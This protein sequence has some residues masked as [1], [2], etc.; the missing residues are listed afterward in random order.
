MAALSQV[1]FI[2]H[3]TFHLRFLYYQA[4]KTLKNVLKYVSYNKI[5]LI[6]LRLN[7]SSF[8]KAK[9]DIILELANKWM[10]VIIKGL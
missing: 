10:L 6:L 3:A 7:S 5:S 8:L 9:F 2:H 4:Y 1:I